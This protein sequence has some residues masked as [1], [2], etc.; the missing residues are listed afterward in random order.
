MSSAG[1]LTTATWARESDREEGSRASAPWF[2]ASD[3]LRIAQ[4]RMGTILLVALCVSAL[5]AAIAFLIP[6]SYSSTAEVV[7]DQ[8]KNKIADLSS[9]L[10]PPPN[11]NAEYALDPASVQNQ[12]HLL[13]SRNL[14]ARVVDR[15]GLASDSELDSGDGGILGGDDSA[16]TAQSSKDRVVDAFLRRLRVQ[17][18]GVSTTLGIT[19]TS[20]DPQMAAAVANAVADAYI[21]NQIETKSEASR[22]AARW[23]NERIARLA[24]DTQKADAAV[25]AY[26]R[27][28]MLTEAADGT[29]LVDQE[30]M[31]VQSQLVQART[32]LAEKKS[33]QGRLHA[34]ATEGAAAD[35]SEVSASAVI[36]QLRQQ[37]ADT[38]RQQQDLATRY[39]PRNPKLLAMESQ[40]RSIEEKI[41]AE[42]S[43]VEGS[44]DSDVAEAEAQVQSLE[45]SLAGVERAA[46][47][48]NAT[49]AML[50]SLEGNAKST[51]AA[52]EE[53]V[54]RLREVQGQDVMQLPDAAII[55]RAPAP[56]TPNP[57]R[58][59]LI[60][61]ASVPVGLLIGLLVA[62]FQE[63]GVA[64]PVIQAP[65]PQHAFRQGTAAQPP[66]APPPG[67]SDLPVVARIPDLARQGLTAH[68]IVDS[69]VWEPAS[70]FALEMSA[71]AGRIV[72]VRTGRGKVFGVIAPGS[73]E[74]KTVVAIALARAA[75][76]RGLNVALIDCDP[77]HNIAWTLR[78]GLDKPG[79]FDVLAG[80]AKLSECVQR[81][82]LFGLTILSGRRNSGGY[83]DM[84]TMPVMA[85]LVDYLCRS[86]DLVVLDLPVSAP[87][88]VLRAVSV[89]ADGLLV[90]LGW[91]GTPLPD[92]ADINGFASVTRARNLG[93]ILAE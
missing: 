24:V 18:L 31:A 42:I 17:P 69:L 81:D 45:A 75:A 59:S 36:V 15:L 32:A 38:V 5:A 40:R 7:F 53:F 27:E 34:L 16:A 90:A 68:T 44:V 80:K 85:Q 55:S 2:D 56:D 83:E 1:P 93:L 22:T 12:I 21:E 82:R 48:E 51:R 74:G 23:L 73:G 67:V 79:L 35:V 58:R 13:T 9:L 62:L 78:A 43:R 37:E 11:S 76:R 30:V 89:L 3:V 88:A 19:Y 71:L 29:P 87:T 91:N 28:H 47:D 41:S 26:K 84:L 4:E 54:S 6:L 52:Y 39:G 60:A 65:L 77:R 92:V 64:P 49:R 66:V 70:P 86:F 20:H 25:E 57:P 63:R 46:A 33:I 8:H 10:S 50:Q 61:L 72:A 14:A